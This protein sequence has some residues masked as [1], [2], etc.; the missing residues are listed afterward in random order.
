MC[1]K[2]ARFIAPI[3]GAALAGPL[4]ISAGLGAAAGSA[5]GTLASGGN[6]LQALASGIG[7]Y[8]GGQLLGGAAGPAGT[9]GASLQKAGLSGLAEALPGAVST[10]NVQ[11]ALGSFMGSNMGESLAAPAPKAPQAAGPSVFS[12]SAPGS[13]DAPTTELG[14]LS[15]E[16]AT[17]SI[18]TRGLYGGGAGPQEQGY[19]ANLL[20]RRLFDQGNFDSP[21]SLN[22]VEEQYLRQ[23]MGLSFG[24]DTRSLLQALQTRR[25]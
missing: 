21:Y 14:M 10:A 8:A 20:Q 16:Q 22:P 13:M 5:A 9:V 23:G 2:I 12:P 4:G 15:P 7:S 6:P 17:A 3:A 24:Q 1:K 18:A 25:A 11:G 19:F